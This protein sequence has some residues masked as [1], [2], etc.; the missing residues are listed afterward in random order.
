M[1]KNTELIECGYGCGCEYTKEE[2]RIHYDQC[3]RRKMFDA[4]CEQDREDD[5]GL[6]LFDLW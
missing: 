2:M 5:D 1:T 6:D 4:D 3:D